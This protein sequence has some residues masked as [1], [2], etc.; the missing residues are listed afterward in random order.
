MVIHAAE[1]DAVQLQPAPL[2]TVTDPVVAA[3]AT[4]VA[5]GEIEN[6]QPAACVSVKVW[7]AMVIVPVREDV[8]LLA[9]TEYET[10]P[11][12]VPAAPAVIVI[13]AALLVADHG[14]VPTALTATLPVD[15]GPA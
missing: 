11:L 10:V 8:E 5:L 6:V 13:H 7:P 15:A 12:P 2:E 1:L 14:H 9:A 3:A 4:D